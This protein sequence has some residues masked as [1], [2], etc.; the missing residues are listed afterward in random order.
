VTVSGTVNNAAAHGAKEKAK[1][2]TMDHATGHSHMTM[3]SMKMVS[4]GCNK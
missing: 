1:E 4:D 2:R 3:T